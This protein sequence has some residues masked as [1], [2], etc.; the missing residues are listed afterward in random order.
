MRPVS[1]TTRSR[2]VVSFLE[3]VAQ[4]VERPHGEKHHL[5]IQQTCQTASSPM[6]EDQWSVAAYHEAGHCCAYCHFNLPFIAVSI[7]QSDDGKISGKTTFQI[8]IHPD[9]LTR[10]ICCISG[11]ISEERFTGVNLDNQ[12]HSWTDVRHA[13]EALAEALTEAGLRGRLDVHSILPFTRTMIESDWPTIQLIASH[14]LDRK[15]LTYND[16]LYLMQSVG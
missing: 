3:N 14:L 2:K 6:T 9:P 11:P 12:H 10:A 7:Y 1:C 5:S 8:G 15:D 13:T 16:V 4:N